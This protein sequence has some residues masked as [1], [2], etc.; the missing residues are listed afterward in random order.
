M[1]RPLRSDIRLE[2]K[3]EGANHFKHEIVAHTKILIELC[4]V[5]CQNYLLY[6][7]KKDNRGFVTAEQVQEFYLTF[8]RLE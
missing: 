5:L 3:E 2:P 8:P 4:T 1:H 7:K 6:L